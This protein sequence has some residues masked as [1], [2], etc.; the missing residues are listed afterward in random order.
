MTA[1]AY[2]SLGSNIGPGV[3]TLTDALVAISGLK[4]VELGATS[5]MYLTKPVGY[6]DQSDFTNAVCAVRCS[7]TPQEL[8]IRLL[9]IEQ[10]FKRVRLFK[11]GPRTLDLDLLAF[12]DTV[13][14]SPELTLPHP[15]MQDRAFVLVPLNDI[16]SDYKVPKLNRTVYELLTALPDQ[17]LRNVKKV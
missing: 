12:G 15:R 16:A 10:Q 9:E 13:C 2:I 7:V 5:P 11:N 17:E 1:V 3:K 4:G 6:P 14:D 8:L